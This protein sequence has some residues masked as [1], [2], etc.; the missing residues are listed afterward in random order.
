MCNGRHF[1]FRGRQMHKE[2]LCETG[3]TGRGVRV[4]E[5]VAAACVFS[6]DVNPRGTALALVLLVAD[7][8]WPPEVASHTRLSITGRFSNPGLFGK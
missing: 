8:R 3:V 6:A 4:T 1:V 7:W 5:L 2:Y